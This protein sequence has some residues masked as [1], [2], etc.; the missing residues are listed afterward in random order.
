MTLDGHK[1]TFN[2]K[3][4]F[5]LIETDDNTFTLQGRM[6]E[7]ID[8]MGQGVGATVFTSLVMKQ[9][10]ADTVQVNLTPDGLVAIVNGE[11]VDFG[12]MTEQEFDDVTVEVGTNQSVLVTFASGVFIEV[13][14]ANDIISTMVVSLPTAMQGLTRGL[15]GNYNG[16]ITDD[17]QP[18]DGSTTLSL[19]SSLEVIHNSFGVTCK[20][21]IVL[22]RTCTLQRIYMF[23]P[24]SMSA[25]LFAPY[26]GIIDSA[27]D[28]LFTYGVNE[29]WSDFYCPDFEPIFELDFNSS[30]IS[31][32]VLSI[33]EGDPF[34]IFDI[35]ATG[36]VAIGMATFIGGQELDMITNLSAP[37][38][39]LPIAT[40]ST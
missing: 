22:F 5:T 9:L 28:S 36:N 39:F 3:G 23:T 17:L 10:A 29:S 18:K 7:A 38:L 16:N 15:M 35:T 1:Y 21:T 32:D 19:N 4:E 30:A 24:L 20:L 34:C 12:D 25:V 6:A 40:A 37:G 2:G 14:V 11:Q 8:D 27:N 31:S 13:R 33:C 26:S